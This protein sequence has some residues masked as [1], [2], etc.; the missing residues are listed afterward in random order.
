MVINIGKLINVHLLVNGKI[1][2]SDIAS[3]VSVIS[4]RNA[5]NASMA[6]F[7]KSSRHFPGWTE[8]P[9]PLPRQKLRQDNK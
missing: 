1:S 6:R 8:E 4:E 7:A 9:L 2:K 5:K 3:S